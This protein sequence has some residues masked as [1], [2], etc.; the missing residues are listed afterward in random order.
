MGKVAALY[1]NFS[2]YQNNS[3]GGETY[4]R[5]VE[6]ATAY[7]KINPSITRPVEGAQKITEN[8]D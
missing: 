3:V 1:E 8:V 5:S 7:L 2:W 4:F 6:D